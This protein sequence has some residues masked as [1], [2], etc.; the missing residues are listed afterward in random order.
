MAWHG[1]AWHGMAWHGMAWHGMAWHGMAWHEMEWNGME[2]NRKVVTSPPGILA[3]PTQ[4][5]LV[6]DLA[7]TGPWLSIA[8][9]TQWCMLGEG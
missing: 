6:Q 7:P 9:R 8:L 1:M 2:W 5:V 3:G 4:G